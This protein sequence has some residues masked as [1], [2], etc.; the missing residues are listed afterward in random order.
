MKIGFYPLNSVEN[1]E[2][3]YAVIISKMGS[4]YIYVK[5]RERTTW[6]LP[7]GRREPGELIQD[8]AK[9]ELI[10]E[11]GASRF[12]IEPISIYSV[13]RNGEKSYGQ[14]F[15]AKVEALDGVLEHE[16]EKVALFEK[17]PESLTYPDIQPHLLNKVKEVMG[18]L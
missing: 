14:L 7:G 3:K 2:L 10:E 1:A 11:T 4:A 16:I 17:M 9:R 8:T 18:T 13:E 15:H 12:E 5:H 6:E